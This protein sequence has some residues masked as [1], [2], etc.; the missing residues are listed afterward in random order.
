MPFPGGP[1]EGALSCDYTVDSFDW[2]WT[3]DDGVWSGQADCSELLGGACPVPPPAESCSDPFAGE[4]AGAIRVGPVELGQ[5]FRAY[6]EGE[7]IDVVWGGQGSAMVF[8]R[9]AIDGEEPPSCAMVEASLTAEGMAPEGLTSAVTMRCGESLRL[10]TIVPIGSCMETEPV[11]T[12]L[13]VTVQGIGTTSVTLKV[14]AEA[15]CGGF[16]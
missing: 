10:Y 3:C 12:V 6:E 8:Y 11:D 1:C 4:M 13:E 16:G 15:F 5:P 7:A 2:S 14:P 9:I